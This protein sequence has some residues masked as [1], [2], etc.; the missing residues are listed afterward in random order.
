MI[1]PSLR[2]D[3]KRERVDA[4]LEEQEKEKTK[5]LERGSDWVNVAVFTLVGIILAGAGLGYWL[6][7][8]FVIS[9][10]GNVDVGVAQF[11]KWAIRIV[12][13]TFVFQ[14]LGSSR[15]HNYLF[16]L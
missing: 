14:L 5:D 11:V 2:N 13:I 8:K 1:L 6:V 3:K 16:S 7:R 4:Q 9:D 10:D 12:G 15:N